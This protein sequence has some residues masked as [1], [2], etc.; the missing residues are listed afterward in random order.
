MES[1]KNTVEGG[2]LAIRWKTFSLEQINST[3][4]PDFR[5]W[6]N[7]KYPSKGVLALVASKAAKNQGDEPFLKFHRA[8][9]ETMH[10][11]TMDIS[12]MSLLKEVARDVGLDLARFENEITQEKTWQAVGKDHTE[13]RE[14]YGVFG[15][16]TLVFGE[17]K[18]VFV[19]LQS[20]PE[21][22]KERLALFELVYRMGAKMPYLLELKRP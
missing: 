9:F 21:S 10:D 5:I 14:K 20:I 16:P 6:E 17:G 1:I 7:P 18:P 2:R 22:Q 12:D 4:D 19:K 11:K 8:T 13:S 3:E 15:V